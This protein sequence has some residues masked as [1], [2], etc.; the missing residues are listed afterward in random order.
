MRYRKATTKGAEDP[1]KHQAALF[2][3][4]VAEVMNSTHTHADFF[5]AVKLWH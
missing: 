5:C 3:Q 2:Y 4:L 1:C